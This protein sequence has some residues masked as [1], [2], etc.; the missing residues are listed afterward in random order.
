M[1]SACSP[2]TVRPKEKQTDKM[3]FVKNVNDIK[4]R[5]KLCSG[6]A[7]VSATGIYDNNGG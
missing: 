6:T 5:R 2:V 4:G 7:A 3:R 1:L